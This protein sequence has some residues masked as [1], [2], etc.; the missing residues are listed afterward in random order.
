M[1][2][3]DALG[4]DARGALRVQRANGPLGAFLEALAEARIPAIMIGSMAA[5]AQGAPLMTIEIASLRIAA[6]SR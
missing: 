1:A 2:T 6:V 5:I 4:D 3:R